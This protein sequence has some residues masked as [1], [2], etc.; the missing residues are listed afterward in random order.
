MMRFHCP[1]CQQVLE[2]V[3]P[4]EMFLCPACE[5]WCRIPIPEPPTEFSDGPRLAPS[6]PEPIPSRRSKP[7][8]TLRFRDES[9]EA[10]DVKFEIIEEGV[11]PRR[12]RRR[13]RRRRRA[14]IG[15]DLDY[16]ISPSL[17]L[18][19]LLIP[20]GIY[21]VVLS[22]ML[23]P[24]AG[25]GAFL[26]VGGSIW[27]AFIAA[28]DGLAPALMVLFVPFYSLY[29]LF[30]HFERV[31]VPFALQCLGAIIFVVSLVSSHLHDA[32]RIFAC[33]PAAPARV[34]LAGAAGWQGIDGRFTFCPV[35]RA[36]P[37]VFRELVPSLGSS[38]AAPAE[39]LLAA[40]GPATTS[41]DS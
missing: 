21:L 38:P 40:F 15:F 33:Q 2:V 39:E 23:H 31:I 3:T 13:R 35:P 22:F 32:D 34:A 7:I 36:A 14:R 28:E 1:H 17:I 12:K 41:T 11:E 16:W 4:T 8:T 29:Y 24:G 25:I 26:W 10:E 19:L 18:L 6:N 20:A 30:I 5:L 37:A 9:D 27:F